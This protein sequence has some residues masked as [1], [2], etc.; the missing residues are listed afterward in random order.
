MTEDPPLSMATFDQIVDELQKRSL[1]CVVACV[2]RMSNHEEHFYANYHGRTIAL[3]LCERIKH[4]ILHEPSTEI[5]EDS[6]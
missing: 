1:G 2:I 4:N 3:G 6:G 5:P